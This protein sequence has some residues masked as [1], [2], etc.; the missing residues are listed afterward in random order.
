MC[1][2]DLEWCGP[3]RMLSPVIEA[4][5][6]KFSN[7]KVLKLNTDENPTTSQEHK[8]TGIPCCILFKDGAEVSRI[9]GYKSESAFEAEL[10]QHIEG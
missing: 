9:V 6:D 7:L 10:K 2:S 1:S 5:S 4:M 3:C 8:I